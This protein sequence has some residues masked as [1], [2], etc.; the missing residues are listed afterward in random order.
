MLVTFNIHSVIYF[1]AEFLPEAFSYLGIT[2][3]LEEW[4]QSLNSY[5]FPHS[6]P[7]SCF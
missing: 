4:R 5:H 1:I 7:N 6:C 2:G 3:G